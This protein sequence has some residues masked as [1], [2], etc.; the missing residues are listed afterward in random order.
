MLP[1]APRKPT[2]GTQCYKNKQHPVT[3][4]STW[5]ELFGT[6]A[7]HSHWH[8]TENQILV[9]TDA[10]E[11]D[12]DTPSDEDPDSDHE[13]DS[14]SLQRVLAA[15]NTEGPN[16]AEH[17]LNRLQRGDLV[18]TFFRALEFRD[19]PYNAP[20]RWHQFLGKGPYYFADPDGDTTNASQATC[21][22]LEDRDY[23]HKLFR[24][25]TNGDCT[26]SPLDGR[27]L[28][29]IL[30]GKVRTIPQQ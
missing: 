12:D 30:R 8:N 24:V 28:E 3:R 23:T 15:T 25:S 14:Q 19:L 22:A 7:A 13:E 29:S 1:A 2:A 5:T 21:I 11:E 16:S 10:D 26:S 27:H 6:P 18:N 17:I 4:R 20:H 9:V